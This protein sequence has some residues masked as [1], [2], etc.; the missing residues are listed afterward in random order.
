MTQYGLIGRSLSH[1]FSSSFFNKKFKEEN[2]NASYANYELETLD[3]IKD[4]FQI[5]GL[6][7][8]NVTIP[9][10]EQIIPFL[11][12]LDPLAEKLGSVNTIKVTR[13]KGKTEFKGFNTDVFGFHQLIRTYFKQH[14]EKA[15]ILGTGGA[16]KAVAHVLLEYGIDVNFISRKQKQKNIYNWEE[17]NAYFIKHHLLIVNTTPVGM[18]PDLDKKI[19]IFYDAINSKHLVIDLIY[20]PKETLFLKESKNRGAI[21]LNGEAMLINQAFKSWEIWNQ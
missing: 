9:Y 17:M 6:N 5:N 11:D 20:N 3:N 2:I 12:K 21:T 7:G 15:L 18:F 16:S 10:K 8:L 14:H 1:S 13:E 19:P 4:V